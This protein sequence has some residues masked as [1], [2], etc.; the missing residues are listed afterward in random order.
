MSKKPLPNTISRAPIAADEDHFIQSSGHVRKE[1]IAGVVT[2]MTNTEHQFLED[3]I[4]SVINQV[5]HLILCVQHDSDISFLH[6]TLSAS[7]SAVTILSLPLSPPGII[8][9]KALEHVTQDWV[10]F[11]DSDDVWLPNKV[12]QQYEFIRHNH[13]DLCGCDHIL[14][15]EFGNYRLYGLGRHIPMVSSWLV[16]TAI[17]RQFPFADFPVGSDGEWWVWTRSTIAKVR[18][19][20]P[21]LLYRVRAGSV[22]DLTPSKRRKIRLIAAAK[23]PIIGWLLKYSTFGLWLLFRRDRYSWLPTW[24]QQS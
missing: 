11:C 17:L 10:A 18:L 12:S 3:S 23:I 6:Q 16:R 8:R 24:P 21:L 5:D 13:A 19:A 22:S 14:M 2:C 1:S 9:N 4:K 20:K 15:D 7:K